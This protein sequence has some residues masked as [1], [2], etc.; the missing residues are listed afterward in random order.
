MFTETGLELLTRL[1]K[2]VFRVPL[3]GFVLAVFASVLAGSWLASVLFGDALDRADS[4][5]DNHKVVRGGK[6]ASELFDDLLNSGHIRFNRSNSLIDSDIDCAAFRAGFDDGRD[7]ILK[8]KFCSIDIGAMVNQQI[9]VWNSSA[10]LV[11]VRDNRNR[12]R[13]RCTGRGGS[14]TLRP[15]KPRNY[16]P[17][18]CYPNEWA[19]SLQNAV[20]VNSG[21]NRAYAIVNQQEEPDPQVYGFLAREPVEGFGDWRRF[22]N[23]QGIIVAETDIDLS[24]QNAR[25]VN[26]DFIGELLGATVHPVGSTSFALKPEYIST[27]CAAFSSKEKCAEEF[28]APDSADLPR[29]GRITYPFPR[30]WK[31]KISLELRPSIAVHARVRQLKKA[32]F[33]KPNDGNRVLANANRIINVSTNVQAKCRQFFNQSVQIGTDGASDILVD[34]PTGKP[35]DTINKCMLHWRPSKPVEAR[36]ITL[37]TQEEKIIQVAAAADSSTRYSTQVQTGTAESAR[38]IN[39][40]SPQALELGLAPILGFD[41]TDPSGLLG[42]LS[43]QFRSSQAGEFSLTIDP[44]LQKTTANI[45]DEVISGTRA[46]RDVNAQLLSGRKS[47]RK[48][49]LLLMDAGPSGNDGT[50]DPLTGRILSV[51]SWPEVKRNLSQWDLQAQASF[52]PTENPLAARGWSQNNRLYAPGSSFKPAIA[53]AAIN[54]AANGD[55]RIAEYLGLG[56]GNRG[57][58]SNELRSRIGTEFAFGFGASSLQVPRFSNGR[59]VEDMQIRNR[60]IAM[61]SHIS[62]TGCGNGSRLTM[63]DMMATSDNIYF[64]R[65]ALLI[66]GENVSTGTGDNRAELVDTE[67]DTT[68][69]VHH[70]AD[71]MNH[72]WPKDGFSLLQGVDT[73]E[74]SRL[75]T[76]PFQID[77]AIPENPRIYRLA[78]NGIGQSAQAT[79]LAM[80]TLAASISSGKVV[81]PWLGGE[82]VNWQSAKP[83]L[84]GN[85]QQGISMPVP[86]GGAGLEMLAGLRQAMKDVVTYG[87]AAGAFPAVKN[88]DDN[89]FKLREKV[90]GKTGTAQIGNPQRDGNTVWFIGWADGLPIEGYE[91]RR[92]AFACMISHARVNN[93]GGGSV[94]APVIRELL[95]RLIPAKSENNAQSAGQ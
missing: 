91:N 60:E 9:D 17:H 52:L 88:E 42:I 44:V 29:A 34:E 25:V 92:I 62:D 64:A 72:V 15:D 90:F 10:S 37:E 76:S 73:P 16:I 43:S 46:M 79:P 75:Y 18:G 77:S 22:P 32:E 55:K 2:L 56:A 61:C 30:N 57:L 69:P 40:I 71:M 21:K 54:Q 86:A 39:I 63:P 35:E 83:L 80:A 33:V 68:E 51:S 94:C 70:I 67:E 53:L 36:E 38:Q 95:L 7:K 24:R 45:L 41:E 8:S 5:A 27:M 81:Q 3:Y 1:R 12:Y 74:F 4:I 93:A 14:G 11:A 87:T 84:F 26:I 65:L 19:G 59:K 47:S 78:L 23:P 28:E 6:L 89:R 50:L 66:D 48:A 20:R 82:P 31:G 49:T 58:T 85:S 13:D